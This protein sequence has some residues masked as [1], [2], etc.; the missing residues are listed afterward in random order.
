MTAPQ[1]ARLCLIKF[2]G[3]CNRLS[4]K[5]DYCIGEGASTM[6]YSLVNRKQKS[7]TSTQICQSLKY[8]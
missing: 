2:Q 8:G 6:R 1:L 3:S 5:Q 7:T 4:E